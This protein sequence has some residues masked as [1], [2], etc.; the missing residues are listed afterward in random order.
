MRRPDGQSID[1][2]LH[3]NSAPAGG[4]VAGERGIVFAFNPT[5]T[6]LVANLTVPLYYTGLTET[7]KVSLEDSSNQSSVLQLRRDYTVII[8]ATVAAGGYAWWAIR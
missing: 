7:A 4:P 1:A 5:T 3:A 2:V 6:D 8:E